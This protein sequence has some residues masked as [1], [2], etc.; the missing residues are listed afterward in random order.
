[1]LFTILK[2]CQS[3]LWKMKSLNLL[4]HYYKIFIEYYLIQTRQLKSLSTSGLSSYRTMSSISVKY[5]NTH[6]LL[7]IFIV[8]HYPNNITRLVEL[9]V[10]PPTPTLKRPNM[11]EQY[12]SLPLP[13]I[14]CINSGRFYM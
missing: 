8:N 7:W 6:H 4:I 2:F 14:A 9:E 13:L 3:A 12:L 5:Y 10:L 1:M 11:K